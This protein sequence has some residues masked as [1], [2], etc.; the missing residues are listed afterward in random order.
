MQGTQILFILAQAA[1]CFL[2]FMSQ[3][4]IQRALAGD[5]ESEEQY[6]QEASWLGPFSD[7]IFPIT[8][9]LFVLC[10]LAYCFFIYRA[11]SNIQKANARGHDHMPT[12]SVG[13]GFVPLANIGY[14]FIIMKGIWVASHDPK[15]GL[16]SMSILLP[17]W[18]GL[19]LVGSIL[20]RLADTLIQSAVSE[21]DFNKMV[22]FSWIGVASSIGIIASSI[23]LL[24]IIRAIDRAQSRWP[25]LISDPA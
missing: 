11:A 2:I 17:L 25:T 5:F 15:Q 16:Y 13:L 7:L 3:Y 10:V 12:S 4:F 18:W 22:T 21:G 14:I 6:F 8:A 24:I 1:A 9:G 19:Y 20:G 23:T